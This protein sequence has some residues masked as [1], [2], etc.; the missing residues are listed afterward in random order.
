LG[1][2]TSFC[3]GDSLKLDAGT[4]GFSN[5]LWSTGATTS[6]ITVSVSG[7]FSVLVGDSMQCFDRDTINV[8][9]N[10]LPVVS[11]GPLPAEI[12][13]SDLALP[14]S[15]SPTGGTFGGNGVSGNTFDPGLAGAGNASITYHYVDANG[16]E[17]STKTD[18]D[19]RP[20][21]QVSLIGLAA[22]Y[23]EQDEGDLLSFLPPGGILSGPGIVSDSF[24]PALAGTGG[25]YAISYSYTDPIG[26]SGTDTL[27]A[28]VFAL[29]SDA[30][31]GPDQSSYTPSGVLL[32][33]NIPLSG[34]G[35]WMSASGQAVFSSPNSPTS[36]VSGLEIGTNT[37]TW[38]I[39]LPPCPDNSDTL[40]ILV[41]DLRIPTGFS[42]NGDGVN[43]LWVINGIENFSESAL[44]IFTRWGNQV[45]SSDNY[46]NEWAGINVDGSPLSDD[47]YYYSLDLG[48]AGGQYRGFVVIKR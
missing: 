32:N 30:Q 28:T 48:T 23:C 18:I 34:T 44:K 27:F 7:S 47:T 20:D 40:I 15:G 6:A 21:P 26:C 5:Y 35:S 17:D 39:S 16:C 36:N 42:P 12:C 3:Q 13:R 4:P 10:P 25:P 29:P 11:I 8:T 14:L 1:Q 33:A 9:F 19:V 24:L 38:T 2:D 31:A 37:L 41:N 45:Y 43:D 22:E 46:L